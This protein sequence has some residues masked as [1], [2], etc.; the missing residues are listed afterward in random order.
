MDKAQ[1]KLERN[2]YDG[3]SVE[4]EDASGGQNVKVSFLDHV[5]KAES[6]DVVLHPVEVEASIMRSA[7][8]G[9]VVSF[10]MLLSALLT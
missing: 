1:R 10:S 9:A 7:E 3:S 4:Q 6:W 8:N 5:K 2:V